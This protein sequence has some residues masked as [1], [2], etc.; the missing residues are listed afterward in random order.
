MTS[1]FDILIG[2][3]P[4][5]DLAARMIELEVEE[6]VDMPGAFRLSL[7]VGLT[8]AGDYDVVSDP[9]L[10]PFSNIAV[11]AKAADNQVHCLIDG[12]VL[13]HE[14]HPDT[15]TSA[16]KLNVSGQD[17]TWLMNATEVVR[18]WADV[19]D[20]AAANTIFSEYGFT[21]TDAYCFVS[22]CPDFRINVYQMCRL[23]KLNYVAG[24]EVPKKYLGK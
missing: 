6:N 19:T 10:G 13:A 7:S 18:E 15:G 22:T 12:Y 2:G 23:G 16:S 17:A 5:S 3:S 9:R 20:G 11:T 21:P 24:A 14:V 8:S 1:F 4:A